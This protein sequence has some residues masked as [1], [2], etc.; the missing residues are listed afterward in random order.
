M[1]SSFHSCWFPLGVFSVSVSVL[2]FFLFFFFPSVYIFW[3]R[4]S[5][6]H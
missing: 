1:I 6:W 2:S 5:A 3:S 4:H